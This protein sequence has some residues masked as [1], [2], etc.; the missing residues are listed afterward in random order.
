MLHKIILIPLLVVTSIMSADAEIII[1]DSRNFIVNSDTIVMLDDELVDSVAFE[2]NSDGITAIVLV[3][4]DANATVTSGT[5]NEIFAINQ[6]KG[7]VTNLD[8]LQVF[9]QNVIT[10]AAT[11]FAN[12][13]GDFTIG[14]LLEVS[15]SFDD[16]SNLLATRIESKANIDVWKLLAHVTNVVGDDVSFGA[17]TVN[18]TGLTLSDCDAGVSVQQ[19]VELKATPVASFSIANTLNG[20]TKFECKNGL[21]TIGT[22]ATAIIG[23]EIEGFVTAI[24]DATH[25]D[26]NTQPV[27]IS[28]NVIYKNGTVDDLVLGVKLEV[29]GTFNTDTSLFTALK[30]DFRETKARI[31][32]PVTIADLDQNQI[33]IMGISGAITTL[34]RDRDNLLPA[35][36]NQDT[37]IE[38]RGFVDSAGNLL[39]EEFRE[40][41]NPDFSD[42]RLRGPVSNIVGN[43]FEILGVT[44]DVT[45]ATFFD[46]N[47]QS[48]L[49][50]DFITA[51]FEGALVDVN[52]GLYDS[53]ANQISGGQITLEF[54]PITTKQFKSKITSSIQAG[55]IAGVG[56]GRITQYKGATTTTP[57]PPPPPQPPV[58]GDGGGGGSLYLLLL[59][60]FYLRRK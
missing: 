41:G 25:F 35:G 16:N 6:I 36:L 55:G 3:G 39:I 34:T 43:G 22:T 56:L 50:A 7:P 48:I 49:L 18:I 51:L 46:N 10:T 11:V 32:A 14:E 21:V 27:E 4:D 5:A 57:P 23:L 30:I 52:H 59:P 60:L 58:A 15:G 17:L 2:Q 45:G 47:N 19:L 37:Q 38:V 9:G 44:V 42:T 1:N 53:Q 54:T 20:L 31:E 33:T 24:T 8:P 28:P 40:R 12:T 26:I 13:S 29:E